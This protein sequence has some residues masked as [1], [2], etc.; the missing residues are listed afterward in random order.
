[1]GHENAQMVYEVYA[2]WIEELSGDQV[3]MLNSK[4]AL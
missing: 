2:A 3:N 1:M 4:L